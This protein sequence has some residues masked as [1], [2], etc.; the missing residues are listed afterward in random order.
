MVPEAPLWS[1]AVVS[2]EDGRI[3]LQLYMCNSIRSAGP[4]VALAVSTPSATGPRRSIT[5]HVSGLSKGRESSLARREQSVLP[6]LSGVRRLERTSESARVSRQAYPAQCPIVVVYLER[7]GERLSTA[8]VRGFLTSG[9]RDQ[10]TIR[11]CSDVT[12]PNDTI[13][14]YRRD[15]GPCPASASMHSRDLL[16][17]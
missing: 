16:S 11:D 9:T 17:E 12:G 7:W 10:P 4:A 8:P 5:H 15:S 3:A 1:R 13:A 14:V 2:G 6:T